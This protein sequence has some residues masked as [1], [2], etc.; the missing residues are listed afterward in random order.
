MD[1]MSFEVNGKKYSFATLTGKQKNDIEL[2]Y[3]AMFAKCLR[4]EMMTRLQLA[5]SLK[6]S[7]AWSDE[8]EK[9]IK[10]LQDRITVLTVD[11]L[12]AKKKEKKIDLAMQ[13]KNLKILWAMRTNA[14]HQSFYNCI[15]SYAENAKIEKYAFLA[16]V[17]ETGERVFKD[18]DEFNPDTD[19]V[20][21]A[22]IYKATQIFHGIS[23]DRVE[24]EDAILKELG[25]LDSHG[26]LMDAEGRY[27][28]EGGQYIDMQARFVD[29]DG[30]LIN[31]DGD[32]I[33]ETGEIVKTTE[34]VKGT[35]EEK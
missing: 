14:Y 31:S 15:E 23:E 18:F 17:D 7:G 35:F 28:T 12:N 21:A 3:S 1:N 33:D 11:M 27:I 20:V 8:L 10:G 26:R 29:K 32:Y 9:D 22:A 16:T 6:K 19:E 24:P 5:Q 2:S 4:L 13:I 25:R 30:Y 34:K